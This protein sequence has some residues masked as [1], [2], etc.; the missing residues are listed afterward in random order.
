[1]ADNEGFLDRWS[2][3]KLAEKARTEPQ[4]FSVEQ[5]ASPL[6]EIA[7]EPERVAAE[8]VEHSEAAPHPAE[9]IDIDSLD[10]ASDFSIFLEKGVPAAIKRKALRKLWTTDPVLYGREQLNDDFDIADTKTWGIGPTRGTG[11]KLGRGFRSEEELAPPPRRMGEREDGLHRETVA[12]AEDESDGSAASPGADDGDSP[13]RSAASRDS[14][15]PEDG[16]A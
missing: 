14:D 15:E 9:A 8:N 10:G 6:P 1:M 4:P 13:G 11:W 7:D 2:R 3:R 5:A 12:E 16:K